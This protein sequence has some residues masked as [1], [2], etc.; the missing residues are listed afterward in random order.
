MYMLAVFVVVMMIW[1]MG[2]ITAGGPRGFTSTIDAPSLA[3]ILLIGVSVLAA[4]G[5]WKDFKNAF[6]L[7]MKKEKQAGLIEWK[8]AKEAV[9]L[10]MAAVRYGGIFVALLQ[11]ISLAFYNM[12]E[13]SPVWWGNLAVVV[14]TPLY[15]YAVNILL[16]PVRS[17]INVNIIEYMQGMEEREEAHREQ[18]PKQARALV[19]DKE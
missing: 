14:V 12:T 11:F 9:E 1:V 17:R 5:F 7:A 13:E 19:E 10:L 16:L 4:S 2:A 8:R 6:R 18:E 3:M 15:A